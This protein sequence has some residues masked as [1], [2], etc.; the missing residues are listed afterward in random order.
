MDKLTVRKVVC[1]YLDAMPDG[2]EFHGW[3]FK[4]EWVRKTGFGEKKY[5]DTFLRIARM[6]RR[7]SFVL[8]NKA[9]SLYKKV[10]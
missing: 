10:G 4:D 1:D 7:D 9:K 8:V 5:D 3:E 6:Y 2:H